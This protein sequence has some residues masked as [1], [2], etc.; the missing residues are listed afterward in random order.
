MQG[1]PD[2][3]APALRALAVP[4]DSIRPHDRNPRH[5][6]IGALSRSLERFGQT[7]PVI[8][9]A[10]TGRI[11]GGNHTWRAAKALGWSE[12]AAH[13]MDVE[14]TEAEALMV[15]D[16]RIGELGGYDDALLTDILTG[17]AAASALDG[18][19]YTPEQVDVL[20]RGMP[21]PVDAH[22]EWTGMP[23]FDQPNQMPMKQIIVSFGST[24]AVEAFARLLEQN[25][26]MT[27]K[28]VW[29]PAVGREDRKST[30]YVSSAGDR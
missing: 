9:Q 15:A 4:I 6:D 25:I 27:T 30:A 16:N 10:S 28:S 22:A 5:G 8:V 2:Q 18:T 26:T 1:K 12:I 7:K 14:D 29:Y 13:A 23:E 3:L 11:L 19:G 21:A 24:A 17:L 20:L